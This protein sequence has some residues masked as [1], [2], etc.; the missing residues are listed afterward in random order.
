V[1]TRQLTATAIAA[2]AI[3]LLAACGSSPTDPVASARELDG[4]PAWVHQP[5][6]R[7]C[8]QAE[9]SHRGELPQAAKRCLNRAVGEGQTGTLAFIRKTTE[10]GSGVSFVLVDGTAVKM[11]SI[12]ADDS[13]G[14]EG[15]WNEQSCTTVAAL[16][17]CR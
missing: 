2:V 8:G 3:A 12:L 1:F 7:D 4:A 11:A 15:G 17:D 14:G 6:A 16:P 5:T 9:V 10:G 13:Y